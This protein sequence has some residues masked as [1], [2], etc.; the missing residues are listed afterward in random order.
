MPL[1]EYRCL[2]C[3]ALTEAY[4]S[5]AERDDCPPCPSCRGGTKKIIS[6]YRVHSDLEP[7]YDENLETHIQS[8]QHR[9]RVMAEQGVS[10]N[11]GQ[12][13]YTSSKKQRKVG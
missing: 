2:K 7:Y 5:V 13:W 6:G 11:F 12:G 4:R 3:E 10:E 9:R 8:K 1:Y